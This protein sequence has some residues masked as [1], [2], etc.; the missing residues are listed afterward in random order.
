MWNV[1]SFL[2]IVPILGLFGLWNLTLLKGKVRISTPLILA[3]LGALAVL[4]GIAAGGA[5]AIDGLDLDGTTWMTGQ[6]VLV[7][8]GALLGGFAGV[9]FWAPKL[10]GRLLP[11]A[12]T[13][14][15]RHDRV[16]RRA[17][18]GGDPR[19]R[20]GVRPAPRRR[21]R[22]RCRVRRHPRGLVR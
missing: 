6:A 2:A 1:V 4:V 22:V 5:T 10:Y 14:L 19:H 7:L 18:G 12:V 17:G 16:P 8:G 15:G 21:R 9:A 3:Q 20:R 13:R 11:D